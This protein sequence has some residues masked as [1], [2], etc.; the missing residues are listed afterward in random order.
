MTKF[1]RLVEAAKIADSKVDSFLL[2]L[3][4]SNWT[5]AIVIVAVLTWWL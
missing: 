2:K 3:V 5:W 1:R 4:K